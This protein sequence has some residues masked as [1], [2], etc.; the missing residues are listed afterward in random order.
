MDYSVEVEVKK[1]VKSKVVVSSNSKEEAIKLVQHQIDNGDLSM[2][3]IEFD[4]P[5]YLN[6][7]E[8]SFSTT[9]NCTEA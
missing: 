6:Y 7:D 3:D 2:T 1:T 5:V 4:E 9:G 8:G